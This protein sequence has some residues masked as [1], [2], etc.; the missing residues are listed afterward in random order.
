MQSIEYRGIIYD[1]D[2]VPVWAWQYIIL[3]IYDFP[4]THHNLVG[5]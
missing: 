2:C 5:K 1:I 4:H 3:K